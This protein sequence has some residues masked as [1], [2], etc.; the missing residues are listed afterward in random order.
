VQKLS[1]SLK[2]NSKPPTDVS[3]P[4]SG[5]DLVNLSRREALGLLGAAA[6]ASA[7][8]ACSREPGAESPPSPADTPAG[9]D[10]PEKLHY[11]RLFEVAGLLQTGE[12]SPLDLTQYM[13]DRIS[14]F[15]GRLKSY[16]TLTA[17]RALAAARQA[18]Q[19]IGSGQYRGPLHGVPIAVKDLCY[20]AGTRTMGGMAA[21]RDFVPDH[22]ATVVHRLEQAGAVL[23]G[24]LNLTEGAMA[25][26]HPEF[27]IPVNPWGEQLW[28]G[29][30]SS[31][32]G[33]ATAAGLCFASLGSDTG[34]SI[35]FPSM[36]NGIVGLKPTYGRV[37]RYGVMPL[38]ETLDHVGPMTRSVADAAIMLQAMA[39]FDEN[40]ATTL[41]DPVPDLLA[42]PDGGI[43]GLRIGYDADYSSAGTDAGLVAAI[44]RALEVLQNLGAK[45]V[46]VRMP[47]ETG[48]IGDTWFAL[49]AYEAHRAHAAT[50]ASQAD[51]FGLFFRDFLTIG[52]A[53]TDEQYAGAS[54]Q[55]EGF[56][57]PFQAL[58]ES[59]DAVVCPSGGVTFP[60][61]PGIQYGNRE[62]LEPLFAA[63]PMQFTIP[64]DFA[65]T[66]TLTVPCGFSD[67]TV[68]YALQFMGRRLSEGTLLRLGQAYEEATGWHERHPA[69]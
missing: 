12:I 19:E 3:R 28:A 63:V 23:L 32:S 58:L 48:Q 61:D 45:L 24:K 51:A 30:S 4:R 60:V 11:L 42:G 1:E 55:R 62:T 13:L 50:L 56:N 20:T 44:E 26:Y 5:T 25:G 16:A 67:A 9:P 33:V 46:E 21:Y 43:E 59:V 40:D 66:P 15:D 64:A 34:G 2:M 39:G 68:P 38:A 53:I 37:S 35:R 49:C 41:R 6:V 17:E 36:A 69:I 8:P 29:A 7:L 14:R 10:L 47:P 18:E 22:D 52:A 31:G 27:D 54:Q 57:R 65:G